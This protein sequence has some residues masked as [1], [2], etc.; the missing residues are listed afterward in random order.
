MKGQDMVL[1]RTLEILKISQEQ[2]Q[3]IGGPSLEIGGASPSQ[4]SG[5]VPGH[6]LGGEMWITD[7]SRI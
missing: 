2:I 7:R 3:I 4:S 5:P 6:T 1:R